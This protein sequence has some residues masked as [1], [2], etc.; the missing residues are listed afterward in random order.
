M[1]MEEKK[2]YPLLF[3]NGS[4][5]SFVTIAFTILM[6]FL[7]GGIFIW[8]SHTS[9][10]PTPD[11]IAGYSFAVLGTFCMIL[12]TVRYAR[13]RNMRKRNVSQ[14]NTVLKWHVSFGVIA[15]FVLFLHSFGNFNPRSGTYALY[16]MIALVIS[17]F[18]GK[19]LDHFLPR[20]IAQ[21]ASKALTPCGEDRLESLTNEMQ[22]TLDYN[23]QKMRG[24]QVNNRDRDMSIVDS[25]LSPS[26]ARASASRGRNMEGMYSALESS[27]DIAYI[28]MQ[29]LPQEIEQDNAHYRFVP[30]RKSKLAGPGALM[31]GVHDHIHEMKM[32]EKSMRHEQQYRYII[33]YWRVFHILLALA[34]VGM[35]LW[36]LEF[37]FSLLIPVWLHH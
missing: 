16:G 24:F 22:S 14:L 37:A 35:T 12:A 36:H 32:V 9:S 5:T 19:A 3:I 28:S 29:E 7:T 31:P 1:Y 21:E 23:S 34:T 10:D 13:Y 8:Y 11:S 30:D 26:G 4:R 15:L 25:T 18:I 27:W 33:R 6:L 17:G 2:R 20:M